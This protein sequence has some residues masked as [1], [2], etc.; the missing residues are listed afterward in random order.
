M[1]Y[2]D[3]FD[4]VF[5]QFK[6]LKSSVSETEVEKKLYN[7]VYYSNK[8]E[9]NRL[10]LAATTILLQHNIA[11]GNL[12]LKDY[13]E[14]KGHFKSLKFV[15]SSAANKYPLDERIL[16]QANKLTLETYW[17]L[18]DAY[19]NWKEAGQK[20]GE[21]KILKNK[22][23]WSLD[24]EKG[25]IKPHS[26]VETIA[27]N[28]KDILKKFN[29]SKVHFIEKAAFLAF[30]I[31]INQPFPDGNKRTARLI[32]TFISIKEGL[33]LTAFDNQGEKNNFNNALILSYL[34]KDSRIFEEFLSKEFSTEMYKVIE[35]EKRINKSQKSGPTFLI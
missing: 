10:S 11:Q 24:A 15:L 13:L 32:T 17:A 23:L 25:E 26:S 1:N 30:Q 35:Q 7:Y 2:K 29:N 18:E 8:L 28:M 22:I 16:K 34:K 12:P 21:Y 6:E 9:G 27:N 4:K 5:F 3:E 33:P 19:F 14:A 20:L 31:F